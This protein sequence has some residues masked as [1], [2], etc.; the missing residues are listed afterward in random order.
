MKTVSSSLALLLVFAVIAPTVVFAAVSP[1]CW[2]LRKDGHRTEAQ[3]CF[4]GLTHSGDTYARAEGFWGLEEWQ[5]ANE[6]FR[7]ATQP[8]NSKTLYKVRWGMLL[9]ER[10]NNPEAAGLFREAL[11][12]DPT[13]AEAYLGLAIVSADGFDGKAA[14]YAAKAIA[15]DTKLAGAHELLAELALEND[16]RDASHWIRLHCAAWLLSASSN[17]SGV[18]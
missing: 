3:A 4:D 1:D 5:Q 9:H 11:A 18:T 16:D 15:L 7:L 6:Q 12:K 8:S 13:N 17:T 14:E 2:S 10:F